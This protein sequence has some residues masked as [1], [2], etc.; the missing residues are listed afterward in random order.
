MGP[1]QLNHV[2]TPTGPLPPYPLTPHR[3]DR[4]GNTI[5]NRNRNE[6]SQ[7]TNGTGVII[8]HPTYYMSAQLIPTNP[9]FRPQ[10]LQY[11]NYTNTPEND[12][13]WAILGKHNLAYSGP[14]G[15]EPLPVGSQDDAVLT[16]GP[17]RVTNVPSLEGS[18][19]KRN[20]T[21][22]EGG[23]VMRL[24][25]WNNQQAGTMGVLMWRRLG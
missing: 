20:V 3:L 18:L 2:S 23:K 12:A 5:T 14:L 21:L 10:N 25:M 11:N 4:N 1:H 16:H 19:F 17:L 24:R 9:A 7:G 6:T 8:Y 13:E 15:I 22:Y